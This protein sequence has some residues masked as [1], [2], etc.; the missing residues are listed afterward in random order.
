METVLLTRDDMAR[1]LER[2][3]YEILERR[4]GSHQLL[5]VGIQRRGV[6]LAR[7]LARILGARAECDIP[8]GTLDINLYRDD[9]TSLSAMPALGASSIPLPLEGRQVILVDDVLY[10][11]RTVRAALEAILDYGRPQRVE[12]LVLVDRGHRELPIHAD[13]V[14]RSVNTSSSEQVNVLL[15]ELDGV[16]EV[17]LTSAP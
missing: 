5:L 2:L 12:L 17:R 1:T 3:A 15:E 9:W 13:Y 14:G 8:L 6:D 11:G 16:D 7:R 4:R 10:T